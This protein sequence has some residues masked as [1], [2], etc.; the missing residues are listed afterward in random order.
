MKIRMQKITVLLLTAVLTASAFTGCAGETKDEETG[1][2][3]TKAEAGTPDK[4]AVAKFIYQVTDS[5]DTSINYIAANWYTFGVV[6]TLFEVDDKGNVQPLLAESC[7]MTDDLHWT[8]K[9]KKDV[10]FHD[11]TPFNADAVLFTFDRLNENGEIG[12]NFDF[13]SSMDKKMTIPLRLRRRS[14]ME[15]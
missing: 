11:G 3:S 6:E 1:K 4:D 2:T 8:L 7:E 12:G 15:P 14:R 13:I 10:K 9:L 5:F